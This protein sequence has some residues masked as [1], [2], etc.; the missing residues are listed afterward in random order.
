MKLFS[1][2]LILA[3][4]LPVSLYAQKT[5]VPVPSD[6]VGEGN[7]NEAVQ[8]AIDS[9][10]LSN[11][12]FELESY[13]YYILTDTITI[14]QGEHLEIVAPEPSTT[15][16]TAPPQIVWSA[17]I[18][19]S[20]DDIMIDCYGDLTL[21]NVWIRYANTTGD[22]I[23]T[24]I[25]FEDD[26]DANVSGKGEIG[27]FEGVLFDY[28][29][30]P[31]NAAGAVSIKCQKYKGTFRNCYFRNCTDPHFRYWGRALS[32]PYLSSGWHID[33]VLF[34]NCTFANIGYVY[35]QEGGEYG[36]NVHFNHC[37][38]LNVMMFTLQSGWWY[39]MSVTN[40]LWVNAFMLGDDPN[41]EGDEYGGTLWIEAVEDFG[42]VPFTNQDRRILFTH[43]SYFIEDWLVDW[44]TSNLI[45]PQPMLNPATLAF[46]DSVSTES[47]AKV[48]P[49]MNR[50][51]LYDGIDPGFFIPATNIDLIKI[52]LYRKWT[53]SG[54]TTWAYEPDA[55]LQQT[56][57]LHEDL[58]YTNETLKTAAM[59]SF[60]LGDLYHWWPQEYALWKT[61]AE[62][63][64]TTIFDWLE[65]GII[66]V[67]P[68]IT[69]ITDIPG[70]Q[71]KQVRVSWTKSGYDGLAGSRTVT[72]YSLW[73]RIDPIPEGLTDL[74]DKSSDLALDYPIPEVKLTDYSLPPGEWDFIRTV[75]AIGSETYN[76]I[77]PTLSDSTVNNGM[78]WSV[79]V[80]IAHTADPLTF[81]ISEVDSG[82]SLDN[83]IPHAPSGLLAAVGDSSIDL[84]WEMV[85]DTDFN[86][87]AIYRS[88]K[89]GFNPT[90]MKPYATTT[91]TFF[92][93]MEINTDIKYYYRVSA[94]DFSGNEGVFSIEVSAIIT[95]VD[96]HAAGPKSYTLFQNFPN[97]FNPSTTIEFNLPKSE[98][99]KLKVYNLQ[100]K[101]VATL[102]SNKLNQGNHLYTFKGKN[103]ASGVYYYQLMAG[104]YREVKK[105]IL[106][107]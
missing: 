96:A 107:K 40:S 52:F 46:F 104:D 6:D 10:T 35:S 59:D 72:Q 11:T 31:P 42:F 32:F 50:M 91:D 51:H 88:D 80:V 95:T 103:L 105:M 106:L 58:S 83:L 24:C 36:D 18:A 47:G 41:V 28:S 8:Q 100:G 73:R 53:V 45:Q 49:Y 2:L 87:F 63:E 89:S 14:P 16:E 76:V 38:F 34:E 9:G 4:Y 77:A 22:Q 19:P 74:T 92:T 43:S 55:G 12:V 29:P 65:Y 75:P 64:Y 99:V 17:D 44:M 56:W 30:I 62:D 86:Y 61:Q 37:T 71:G 48:Y 39:K 21:K 82:Y 93:D 54:D 81:F 85:P 90:G 7:L 27:V 60:P 5:I 15:Q 13:G 79:F 97:P 57:P 98:F 68:E 26:P 70:D 102:I 94:F 66:E 20:N 69:N 78:C 23:G 1:T 3:V 67:S 25:L 101:E 33:S 84:T